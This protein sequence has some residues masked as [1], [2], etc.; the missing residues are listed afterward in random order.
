M[1]ARGLRV[2]EESP[3]NSYESLTDCGR[4]AVAAAVTRETH[5]PQKATMTIAGV[6]VIR[7]RCIV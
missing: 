5:R 2:D 6:V 3:T 1:V 4:A 7:R